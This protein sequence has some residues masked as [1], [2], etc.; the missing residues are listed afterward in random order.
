[1]DK[2]EKRFLFQRIG[3]IIARSGNMVMYRRWQ[4]NKEKVIK[5][6]PELL[7]VVEALDTSTRK[8]KQS[9]EDIKNAKA[10]S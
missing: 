1:M 3:A 6:F 7:L 10:R 8:L 5:M 9:A 2:P 4:E